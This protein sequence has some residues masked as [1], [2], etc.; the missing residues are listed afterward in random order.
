MAS[1]ITTRPSRA[2]IRIIE[3]NIKEVVWEDAVGF[4]WNK[5]QW[6]ALVGR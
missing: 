1:T 4:M 6:P 2:T 3:L 5:D